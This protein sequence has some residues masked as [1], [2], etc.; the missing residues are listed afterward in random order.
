MTL[1]KNISKCSNVQKM[2]CCFSLLPWVHYCCP[3][4]F[5][6]ESI[7][8]NKAK[9]KRIKVS[10]PISSH[11]KIFPCQTSKCFS[12][13]ILNTISQRVSKKASVRYT[14]NMHLKKNIW[15][16]YYIC[17]WKL[18]KKSTSILAN[19]KDDKKFL[20]RNLFRQGQCY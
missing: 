18:S 13:H 6:Q 5:L 8:L 15:Y 3:R 11:T 1:K 10:G 20:F 9:K 14:K 7:R 2:Y 19:K 4:I 17:K 12:H 16:F